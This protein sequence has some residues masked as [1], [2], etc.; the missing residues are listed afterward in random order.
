MGK[1]PENNSKTIF[2]RGT[3]FAL[4]N[5]VTAMS[6]LFGTSLDWASER[7]WLNVVADHLVD[8]LF[9]KDRNSRFLFANQKVVESFGCSHPNEILGKTD[10]DLHPQAMGQSYFLEEQQIMQSGHP[11]LD[12]EECAV[13]KNGGHRWFLSSKFPLS[14]ADGNVVG[15][16]G[17]ARDIT[18][19]KKAE[20]L[21]VGQARL[22]EDLAKGAPLEGLLR[23]LVLLIEEQLDGV[24]GS[25]L[26]L[27]EDGRRLLTGAGPSLPPDYVEAVNGVE[28]G[29]AVGS[30]GTAA[31]RRETVIVED[32]LTNPLWADYRDLI[33]PTGYRSSWSTPFFDQSGEVLG[34]FALYSAAVRSPEEH[35]RRLISEATRIAAIAVERLRAE[36]QIWSLAHNDVLTGLPNR[37]SL[38]KH[39]EKLLNTEDDGVA[40]LTLVFMD[41]DRFKEINDG[42]G[43]ATGDEVLKE[44]AARVRSEV[45]SQDMVIRFGGDEFVIVLG[46]VSGHPA[47]LDDLLDRVRTVVAAPVQAQGQRFSVTC[48]FGAVRYPQDAQTAGDLLRRADAAMYA[49]KAAGRDRVHFFDRFMGQGAKSRLVL[50]EDMRAGL[51]ENAFFLDYQP[52]FDL[53]TGNIFGAEALVR[54]QHPELGLLPPSEFIPHAEETGLVVELGQW[55]LEEACRQNKRWQSEGL[56]PLLVGVNVSA[57]QFWDGDLVGQVRAAVQAAG[58]SGEYL[59]LEITES[60][61]IRNRDVAIAT[62]SEL[63]DFGVKL[64]IDDF[65]TGYSSLAALKHLPLTRLKID[66]IFTGDISSECSIMQ[67][68]IT[69]GKE[70]GLSVIA[71]GI[72]EEAQVHALRRFGCDE[73]QGFHLGRPMRA[74]QFTK[75]LAGQ[76]LQ[77]TVNVPD[78]SI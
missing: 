48:S 12:F 75:C 42:F 15:I 70:L 73:G 19:R 61:L 54:W 29:E 33:R 17:V 8:Y 37:Y 71:E 23:Q 49:A 60:L 3:D 47:V 51:R 77:R 46:E 10:L 62:M 16:V 40:N 76:R 78:Y 56:G 5:S 31:A 26:L 55:V 20:L 11:K 22:L 39:L 9:V 36:E 2:D 14:G 6:E 1:Q 45:P 67:A 65:G 68:I 44:V 52:Q 32:V 18:P 30:C 27:D 50:L 72:E 64:A 66:R 53:Q 59:E 34:T 41:L 57:R 63:R 25:I 69:L 35:E 38:K 74:D 21:R 7:Q 24:H 28:I 58:I 43:H 4:S 13:T